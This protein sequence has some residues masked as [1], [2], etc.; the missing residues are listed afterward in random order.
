MEAATGF[1]F[2]VFGAVLQGLQDF[3]IRNL[4]RCTNAILRLI[5]TI[6]FCHWGMA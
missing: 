3:H 4:L 6:T 1:P 5:S 2:S